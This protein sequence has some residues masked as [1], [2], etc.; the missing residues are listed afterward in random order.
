MNRSDQN[1][2]APSEQLVLIVDP[3]VATTKLYRDRCLLL[4]LS[5]QTAST[6]EMAL[7]KMSRQ[8]PDV[9]LLDVAMKC[10]NGDRFLDVIDNPKW[11]VPVVGLNRDKT[12]VQ[13]SDVKH[14][15]AYFCEKSANNWHRIR[16]FLFELT[17]LESDPTTET[18]TSK[19]V[20]W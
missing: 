9:L 18:A 11:S 13:K 6:A 10:S 20:G 3:D 19:R 5:V 1:D 16:T 8:L 7:E 14:I 4:G 2:G 15:C 17:E 12:Q